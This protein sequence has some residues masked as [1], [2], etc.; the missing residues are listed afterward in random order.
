MTTTRVTVSLPRELHDAVQRCAE[1]E[2]TP[3]SHLVAD[4]L[5]EH[6]RRRLLDEWLV[7]YQAEHGEFTE[8]ELVAAA[9]ATGLPYLPPDVVRRR[10]A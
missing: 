2:G 1:R 8:D 10:V 5:T 7:D 4:A 3:L 9:R 6:L